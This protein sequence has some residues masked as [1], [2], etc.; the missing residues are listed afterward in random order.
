MRTSTASDV[1]V[2][3]RTLDGTTAL[4]GRYRFQRV[5]LDRYL[6]EFSYAG[7]WLRNEHGRSFPLRMRAWRDA[8]RA[9]AVPAATIDRL[10]GVFAPLLSS[11]DA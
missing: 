3:A 11:E 1:F 7:S 8:F 10:A 4:V 9:L 5:R 2:R 6:G